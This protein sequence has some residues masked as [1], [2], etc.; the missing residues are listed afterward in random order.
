MC[1]NTSDAIINAATMADVN[2]CIADWS[3][4]NDVTIR[5]LLI[6]QTITRIGA[7]AFQGCSNLAEVQFELDGDRPLRLGLM[8]FA[9]CNSLR[10]LHLPARITEL[11]K[12]CFR[13]CAQLVS[14]EISEGDSLLRVDSHLFDNCPGQADMEEVVRREVS[15][16]ARGFLPKLYN[17]IMPPADPY[18]MRFQSACAEF[19]QVQDW[20]LAGDDMLRRMYFNSDN[21]IAD[22]GNGAMSIQFANYNNHHPDEVPLI[23]E[24]LDRGVLADICDIIKNLREE[25]HDVDNILCDCWDRFRRIVHYDLTVVFNRMVA[26]LRPDLVLRVPQTDAVEVLYEWFTHNR[27]FPNQPIG[28]VSAAVRWF[29]QNRQIYTFLVD[30]LG[31]RS[32]YEIGAFAWYL[33]KVFRRGNNSPTRNLIRDRGYP[34]IRVWG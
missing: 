34:I 11:G 2:G 9:Q 16:P 7:H 13:D 32:I 12:G 29:H 22:V 23:W 30:C 17:A 4:N 25:D 14:I 15:R 33:A 31:G 20:H 3:H 8:A 26:A 27:I 6:P 1:N 19:A 28:V 21:V 10:E 5:R 18:P 24:N